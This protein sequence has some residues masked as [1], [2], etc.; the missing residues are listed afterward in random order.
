MLRAVN[1][2]KGCTIHATDG[3]IGEV[4]EFYFDDDNWTVRY[5]IADTGRWL[6]GRKV[7]LSPVALGKVDWDSKRLHVAM[8]KKQVENSPDIDTA[9]PVSR[10][11]EMAYYNYYN[12]PYYWN[13]PYLWGPA[14][15]PR[16]VVAPSATGIAA[17]SIEKELAAAT[18]PAESGDVHL[19]STKEVTGYYVE[20]NDGDMG[21][22]DDFI[23]DDEN[24]TVRYLVVDTRNWW[25]GKKV[26]VSPEWIQHVSWSD[27]RVYVDLSRQT[28]Q[29]SPEYAGPGSIDRDYETRLH[30]HYGREGYWSRGRRKPQMAG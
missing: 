22:V 17:N 19:H 23:I 30:G 7:L 6:P 5:L 18:E 20:A 26:L 27:S 12:Y 25:P 8:T 28:I 14:S 29:D 24:W 11:H 21:H 15:Y 13:G 3:D 10:Q 9:K 4:V 2:L 1:D 16:G